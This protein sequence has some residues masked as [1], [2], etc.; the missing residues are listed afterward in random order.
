MVRFALLR[1]MTGM[2]FHAPAIAAITAAIPDN[3]F[4]AFSAST[5][6]LGFLRLVVI[7]FSG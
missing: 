6:Q 7:D 5:S 3:I 2:V 1:R 4:A